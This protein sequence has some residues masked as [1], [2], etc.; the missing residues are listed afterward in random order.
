MKFSNLLRNFA[1]S[2][3]ALLLVVGLQSC[4]PCLDAMSGRNLDRVDTELLFLVKKGSEPYDAHRAAIEEMKTFLGEAAAHSKG[5][6]RNAEAAG[7]WASI[8]KQFG[9]FAETWQRQGKHSPVSVE[10]NAKIIG[11]SVNSLKNVESAKKRCTI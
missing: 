7:I 8:E 9:G 11:R 2:A 4:R 1:L 6:S 5:V 10:E 3:S